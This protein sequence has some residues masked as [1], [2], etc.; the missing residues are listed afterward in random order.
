MKTLSF[1]SLSF[2]VLATACI[3]TEKRLDE[4]YDR[5]EPLRI[6]VESGECVERLDIS[7]EYLLAV[8]TVVNPSAPIL[9]SA[10][11]AIDTTSDPWG[12]TVTMQPISYTDRSDVGAAFT[13]SGT[14]N[15]DGT[16]SLD[17]GEITVLGAANPVVPGVDAVATLLMDGCTNSL[18]FSCGNIGGAIIAPAQLPL[19][20]STYGAVAVDGDLA[21]A[22]VVSACPVAE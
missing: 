1:V 22:E 17:F 21:T 4:F 14:V 20:G 18:T 7:G 15:G 11:F 13:A 12:L 9:F 19:T 10:D 8:A 6:T 16:F 3:D 2:A 5:S